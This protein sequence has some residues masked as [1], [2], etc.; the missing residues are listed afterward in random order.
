MIDRRGDHPA[1]NNNYG[2]KLSLA[3]EGT[4]QLKERERNK[5]P[6]M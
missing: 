1:D 4:G 2:I 5:W 3:L 6:G